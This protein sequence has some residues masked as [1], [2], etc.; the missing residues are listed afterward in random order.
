[1][2]GT[3]TVKDEGVF[4]KCPNLE[5]PGR[6]WQLLKHFVS[7]GAMDVDGLGELQVGALQRAGLVSAPGD[8]YRLTREQL[9]ELEGF[10]EIS[11]DRL[12]AA[13]ES[14]KNRP[15][16]RLLFAVGIEGVG[17]V[18]GGN[19]AQALPLDRRVAGGD[20]RADRADAGGSGRRSRR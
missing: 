3:P 8:F 12:L 19:L 10:G 13:I 14:S 17:F 1:M 15:F 9:L 16:G 6:R 4:T 7:Q 2:C 11:A 18:T 20:A 5:C